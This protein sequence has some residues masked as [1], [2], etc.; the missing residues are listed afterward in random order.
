MDVT[1]KRIKAL[2]N[3]KDLS[4]EELCKILGV[5]RNTYAKWEIDVTPGY[6]SL[7]KLSDF[8]EVSI[9]Y[10][11]G[12]TDNKK[13]ESMVAVMSKEE[14]DLIQTLR[15]LPE[16]DAEMHKAFINYLRLKN[17]G[18]GEEAATNVFPFVKES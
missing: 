9:D 11:L 17:S 2:R 1:A 12:N 15:S 7:K 5:N 14:M 10:I 6:S 16:A 8:Y 18:G 13:Q 3:E 4:Q